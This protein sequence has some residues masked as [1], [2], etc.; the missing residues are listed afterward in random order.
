V[1]QLLEL[2]IAWLSTERS[3]LENIHKLEQIINQ[4]REEIQ[5]NVH[6]SVAYDV[7]FH[8]QIAASTRNT[9]LMNVMDSAFRLLEES[10]K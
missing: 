7:A 9:M 4:Q 8:L 3:T 10:R 1:R 2:Q 5:E 6:F